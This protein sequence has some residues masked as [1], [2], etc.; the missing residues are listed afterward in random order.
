[1]GLVGWLLRAALR[2]SLAG[3]DLLQGEFSI[4]AHERVALIDANGSGKTTLIRILLGELEADG[5]TRAPGVLLFGM[6]QEARFPPGHRVEEVLREGFAPLR[7]IEEQLKSLE[8]RLA[9]PEA[10]AAWETLWQRYQALGG[11]SQESRLRSVLQG[12]TLEALKDREAASLS[13]GEQRR[14]LIGRSLLAGADLLLL[15]EPTNHLD[16]FMRQFLLDY[17]K[18]YPGAELFASHDRWFIEHLADRVLL[19]EEGRILSYAG[20]YSRAMHHHAQTLAERAQR[21]A[22]W[23]RA[24][25]ELEERIERQPLGSAQRRALER[26]L[27][28][29]LEDIPPPAPPPA[30]AFNFRFTTN[31]SGREVLLGRHLVRQP[32]FAI[33]ELRVIRGERIALIGT[34]GSGKSTFLKV[35]LGELPS[36]DPRGEL[37]FAPG[38]RIGYFDQQLRGLDPNRSLAESLAAWLPEQAAHDALGAWGFPFER[39]TIR[40]G[41]LSPGEQA[42]LALLLLSLQ[43]ANL[44]LLDEPTN[45][46]DLPRLTALE[47]ALLAFP[48]TLIVV[49]HD[50]AFVQRVTT[51]T[52]LLEGGRLNELQ[53][54]PTLSSRSTPPPPPTPSRQRSQTSRW[55]RE[56]ARERLE[57]EIGRLEARR[58]KLYDQLSAPGLKPQDYA[59]LAEEDHRL[60]EELKRL[61]AQWEAALDGP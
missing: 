61:Y 23:E 11:P 38:V 39:Q 51:R 9:D 25:R 7:P 37:R 24:T 48:G 58:A 44:L 13:G 59:Q 22:A 17:L 53:G 41:Q 29:Y 30:P 52:W 10:H 15:D 45:H 4:E 43:G 40:V 47:E 34:N 1:M 54:P 32:L 56:R 35:L 18:G 21:R 28:R 26:R 20:P 2:Y 6:P 31:P 5:V 49:S 50:L 42:R 8:A 33:P 14:L 36:Q 27:Q 46:L 60:E 3:R 16:L 12:L 55:H 57:E 19:I